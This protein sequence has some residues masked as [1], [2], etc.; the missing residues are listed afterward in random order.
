MKNRI[1]T[2][3]SILIYTVIILGGVILFA[4][5]F[6]HVDMPRVQP[7][8][9]ELGKQLDSSEEVIDGQ[10]KENRA[11]YDTGKISAR[12]YITRNDS[13]TIKLAELR[14]TNKKVYSAAA[15]ELKVFDWSGPRQFW[16]GF[17]IRFPFVIYAVILSLMIV[18]LNPQNKNLKRAFYFLQ[19]FTWGIAVYLMCWVFWTSDDFPLKAYRYY[20]IA[21]SI[22]IGFFMT[23]L[24]NWYKFKIHKQ[25]LVIQ[26]QFDFMHFDAKEE[27]LI[28]PM[29]ENLYDKKTEELVKEAIKDE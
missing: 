25:Y 4:L 11:F 12:D 15:K 2:V 17:G 23:F 9:V 26:R 20:I 8:L 1:G 7:Q 24:F 21:S 5:P 27:G 28:N 29:K 13:L 10:I 18:A 16:I 19:I 3:K 14:A 6:V 22:A